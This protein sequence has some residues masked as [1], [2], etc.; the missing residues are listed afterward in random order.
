M[1]HEVPLRAVFGGPGRRE[2]ALG[3]GPLV[4]RRSV[5]IPHH[6]RVIQRFHD[7]SGESDLITGLGAPQELMMWWFVA[8]L[9][10]LCF[11]ALDIIVKST[12][13]SGNQSPSAAQPSL[14][15]PL[16]QNP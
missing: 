14:G 8:L 3:R 1:V 9:L 7:S 13:P 11:S 6:R 5:I 4:N 10:L 2:A 16:F 15:K 12:A